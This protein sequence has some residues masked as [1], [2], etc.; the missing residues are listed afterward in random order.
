MSKPMPPPS[1]PR[2]LGI[3]HLKF[4]VSNLSLSL[5]WYERVLG[6]QRISALDHFRPDGDRFAVVC[7]MQDWAGLFLELR[8]NAVKA[9][10]DRS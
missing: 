10:D 8:D 1:R 7:E 2:V 3:H 9:L 6:A 4:P 5:A